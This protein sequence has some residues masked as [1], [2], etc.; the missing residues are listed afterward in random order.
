MK[1]TKLSLLIISAILMASS[2]F[3]QLS[4]GGSPFSFSKHYSAKQAINYAVMPSFKLA[5]LVAEDLVNDQNKGPYRFG[6]NHFVN[7]NMN[8][9]GS[10]T[11]LDNGDRLWQL[12]IRSKEAKSINLA[13]DDF[14]I[15]AGASLFIYNQDKSVVIGAFTSAN[16]DA[17][18]HFATD[19][20]IGDDIILEYYEPSNV[21]KQG[22]INI[23]RVT[24]G[25]RGGADYAK[26]LGS[27]G[28]CQVNINCPLGANWQNEKKGIVCLVVGGSEFCSGTLINDVPQDGKP[29]I[30]TANHCSSSND[31]A[32]WVF[33][34]HWEAPS[35]TNPASS[36][37]S[38]S[39]TG[40]TLRARSAGSDFCLV[41]ITGGLNGGTVPANY[42][43]FFNGWSNINIAATNAIGIHHPSGDIMKIS[44]AANA[45]Q[46]ST[47][48]GADCWRVGEWTTA[49]TEPGSSGSA[50]FDQNHRLIGQL[51]GG[52]SACGATTA[53]NYDNYGKF[54][55]SW[56][57]GGTSGT[58]LKVWLDPSNIGTTTVDG[59]DPNAI[60]P[61]FA[62]D[63]GIQSCNN[64]SASYT[65]CNNSLVPQV[66]MKNFGADTLRSCNIN[67]TI[68]GGTVMVYNWSGILPTNQSATITLPIITGLSVASHIFNVYT[69]NPNASTEQNTANDGQT[70][71]FTITVP[72]P[73]VQTPIAEGFESAFPSTDWSIF[74]PDVDDTWTQTTTAG[75]FGTSSSSALIDNFTNDFRGQS[76][77][78]YS[79]YLDLSL[80]L[81]PVTLTFDVAYARYSA[82]YFDSLKVNATSDCGTTWTKVYS[83]GSTGLA[84]APNTTAEFIPTATQWRKETVNLNNYIGQSAVRLAFENK[85][86]YGQ[87]LYIDNINITNGPTS[88]YSNDFNSSFNVYPNP[89]NGVLNVEINFS[90]SETVTI[91]IMNILG[92][93]IALHTLENVSNQLYKID[94][95][96]Q[97]KGIYFVELSSDNHRSMKKI[98]LV[99]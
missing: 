77:F 48:S 64:P 61:A 89:S 33:R 55:T 46:S 78:I 49:C 30:L 44:E 92:E 88:I 98:N 4:Q 84:T 37:S 38:Q 7:L 23:F 19:L 21:S 32:N 31:M 90:R 59:F 65:S 9:S 63:A 52:P 94:L 6:F 69:S 85:S 57:G 50:L 91:K 71:T 87:F 42:N 35:C 43:P 56:L 72:S 10:W 24:H 76:D 74:N 99:K 22:R 40:S 11:T 93:T 51:F 47:M 66:V 29:Y 67:Y 26:S 15:P 12:G 95:G 41:E 62:L 96:D 18:N 75:G 79:P 17:S 8:N 86:G 54:A 97:A 5:T 14:F 58:Q 53:N 83:N 68:D 27:S 25:Y 36:P 81:S 3:A 60:P 39:L 2:A 1:K 82:T 16:N 20:V 45:T 34:F 73:V 70:S 28:A 80:A 13:M